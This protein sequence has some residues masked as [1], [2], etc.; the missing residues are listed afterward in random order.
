MSRPDP[1]IGALRSMLSDDT[2]SISVTRVSFA[3][4]T[5]VVFVL[6]GALAVRFALGLP[7]P[8]LPASWA[9][10]AGAVWAGVLTLKHAQNKT[11]STPP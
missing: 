8:D 6:L 10:F 2:G 9:T 1:S 4:I 3:A 7:I 5:F 11:E